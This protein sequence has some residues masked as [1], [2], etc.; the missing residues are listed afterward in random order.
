[1]PR[2]KQGCWKEVRYCLK[3]KTFVTTGARLNPLDRRLARGF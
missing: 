1:L 3:Q 2:A